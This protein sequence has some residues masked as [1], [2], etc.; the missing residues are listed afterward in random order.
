MANIQEK[1]TL[2]FPKLFLKKVNILPLP[3]RPEKL[4]ALARYLHDD[5]ELLFDN[6]VAL[7]GM[8][9]GDTLGVV[10]YLTR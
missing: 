6:L 4:P 8:D 10:Y 3:F 2:S 9:W 5:S 7:V 1:I